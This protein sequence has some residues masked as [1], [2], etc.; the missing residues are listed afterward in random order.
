VVEVQAALGLDTARPPRHAAGHARARADQQ[1]GDDERGQHEEGRAGA[2][3][4]ALAEGG[5][6]EDGG[7]D[8]V[9]LPGALRPVD[10][11][12]AQA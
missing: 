11:L 4:G 9:I 8:R 2:G 5:D 6:V 10:L 3:G 12:P 7:G 1:E